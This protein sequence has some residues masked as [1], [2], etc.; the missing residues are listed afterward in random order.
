[1]ASKIGFRYIGFNDKAKVLLVL[2]EVGDLLVIQI[3][4]DIDN[5]FEGIK[6]IPLEVNFSRIFDFSFD[7]K[8]LELETLSISSCCS[9]IFGGFNPK[10]KREGNNQVSS[11]ARIYEK[12][13][14]LHTVSFAE[15]LDHFTDSCTS[16]DGD[17]VMVVGIQKGI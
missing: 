14:G 8:D 13:S 5:L 15:Y 1:M 4:L 12:T 10:I 17:S 16:L 11:V 2:E 9:K 3:T 6:K 7:F